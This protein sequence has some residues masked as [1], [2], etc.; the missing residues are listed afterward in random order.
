MVND[1][2]YAIVPT[3]AVKQLLISSL[4]LGEEGAKKLLA[5]PEKNSKDATA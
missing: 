2:F 1:V 3:V 4:V 5:T